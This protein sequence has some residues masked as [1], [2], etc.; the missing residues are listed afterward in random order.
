M[1]K[2]FVRITIVLV[3]IYFLVSYILAQ[4]WGVDILRNTYI[5]LFETCVV[6]Y[7]FS[8]GKYHCRYIKW[9]ALSILF[10]D[11]LVHIDYYFNIFTTPLHN[12][13]PASILALGIGTSITLAFRHFYKVNKLRN[14][15]NEQWK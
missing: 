6:I 5:L 8:E 10:C 4:F 12:L 3:T 13:L 9:V 15:R 1:G 14:K 11:I 7:T 2:F